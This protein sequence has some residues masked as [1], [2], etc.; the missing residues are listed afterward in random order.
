M[1]RWWGWPL[2]RVGVG[3]GCLDVGL[4]AG[5]AVALGG[6]GCTAGLAVGLV[7]ALAAD[8]PSAPLLLSVNA[9]FC[10]SGSGSEP[11]QRRRNGS[12]VCRPRCARP[13]HAGTL[14]PR[15]AAP[16]APRPFLCKTPL[17]G[18]ARSLSLSWRALSFFVPLVF[19][20]LCPSL[21]PPSSS[22][23]AL[24]PATFARS[25]PGA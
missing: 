1:G 15:S 6:D 25:F 3:V 7:V 20:L 21:F 12:G 9:L 2:G 8:G 13:G 17:V 22:V 19:P 14:S 11:H 24:F 16:P 18:R 5:L 10:F 4:A 23:L